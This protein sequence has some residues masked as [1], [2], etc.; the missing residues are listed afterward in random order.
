MVGG[1]LS[2]IILF[3]PWSQRE[4]VDIGDIDQIPVPI[5]SASSHVP[6]R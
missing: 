5:S 4:G 3:G 6:S 2:S 1:G